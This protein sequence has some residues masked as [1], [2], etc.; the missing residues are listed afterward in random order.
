MGAALHG[1]R[2]GI[3]GTTPLLKTEFPPPPRRRLPCLN[4]Q[5]PMK[6]TWTPELS[7]LM[8]FATNTG[9]HSSLNLPFLEALVD[10]AKKS[11]VGKVVLVSSILTNGRAWGQENS[12]GFQARQCFAVWELQ[13]SYQNR[14]LHAYIYAYVHVY[15]LHRCNVYTYCVHIFKFAYLCAYILLCTYI[16]VYLP[17]CM[18]GFLNYGDSIEVS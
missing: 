18:Y 14:Y 8:V 1:C 7:T 17:I 10:A 15:T 6:T 13:L 2:H 3:S 12:P 4:A 9:S 5:T 11:G 16:R